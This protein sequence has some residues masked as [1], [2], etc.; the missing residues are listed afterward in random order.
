VRF[1]SS[2]KLDATFGT[3]GV[4]M[5]GFTDFIN[6]PNSVAVQPDGDIL[7]A[8]SSETTSGGS[9]SPWRG[10]RPTANWMTPLATAAW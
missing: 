10:S 2:G 3:K 1:T 5:V 4:T 8:G 6:S 9:R 7:V